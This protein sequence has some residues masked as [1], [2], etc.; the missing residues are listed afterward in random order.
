M[1][2]ILKF[3]SLLLCGV[4]IIGCQSPTSSLYYWGNYSDSVYAYYDNETTLDTQQENMLQIIN[5]AQ[6]SGKQVGPGIYAHLGLISLKQGMAQKAQD[7]FQ[8]EMTLYPESATFIQFLQRKN[9][10]LKG[11]VK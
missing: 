6:K 7:Y 4:V 8:K 5:N 1:L 3:V 9:N 10:S 11:V 2:K